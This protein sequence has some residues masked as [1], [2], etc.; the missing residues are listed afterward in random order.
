MP[1]HSRVITITTIQIVNICLSGP[2]INETNLIDHMYSK[3]IYYIKVY[4]DFLTRILKLR[5][6][7]ADLSFKLARLI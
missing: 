1:T 5:K 3:L 6:Q 2:A 7:I 4:N